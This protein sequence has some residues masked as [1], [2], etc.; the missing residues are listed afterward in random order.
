MKAKVLAS[1]KIIAVSPIF[2]NGEIVSYAHKPANGV[3]R[4]YAPYEVDADELTVTDEYS[5]D[6]HIE[7]DM[8]DKYNYMRTQ[9]AISA[10]QAC[11][12][13]NKENPARAAVSYTDALFKELGFAC[14]RR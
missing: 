4:I 2:V 9:A 8:F 13:A 6:E 3:E 10:L 11:I 1:G 14:E 7:E 12:I 5:G